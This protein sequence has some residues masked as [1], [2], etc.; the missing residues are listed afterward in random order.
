MNNKANKDQF[1]GYINTLWKQGQISESALIKIRNEYCKEKLKWQEVSMEKAQSDEQPA[2]V[3]KFQINDLEA[4]VLGKEA[5]SKVSDL[6]GRYQS[7]TIIEEKINS[8]EKTLGEINDTEIKTKLNESYIIRKNQKI[9]EQNKLTKERN[10][11]LILSLGIILILLAGIILATSTWRMMSNSTKT[12]TLLMVSILFFAMSSFT[13]KKLK[14]VKT[15]FAFWVLGNLFLPVILLSIGFFKL[16]GNYLSIGGQGRYIYGILSTFVCLIFFVYSIKKYKNMAFTWIS[17]ID[18]HLLYWFVLKQLH[19][20][21]NLRVIMTLIYIMILSCV[22]FKWKKIEGIYAFV[23]KT[24][25]YYAFINIIVG[26]FQVLGLSIYATVMMKIG[27]SY[28]MTQGLIISFGVIIL[29]IIIVLWT[30]DFKFQGGV[31]VSSLLILAIHMLCIT[32]EI[33]M[34]VFTYYILMSLGMTVVYGTMYYFNDFKYLKKGTDILII[35]SMALLDLFSIIPLKALF[36][37]ILLYILAT[38]IITTSKKSQNQVYV[39]ILKS[40]IPINIFIANLFALS[41]LKLIDNIFSNNKFHIGFIYIILNIGIIYCI[42]FIYGLKNNSSYKIYL[43]EGYAF[44]G[45]IYLL[46]LFFQIDRI[47]AGIAVVIVTAFCFIFS[48]NELKIK[49]YLYIF[50][51]MIILVLFDLELFFKFNKFT[52][53]ILKPQNIFLCISLV[54]TIIWW[55]AKEVWKKRLNSYIIGIYVFGFLNSLFLND[56]QNLNFMFLCFLIAALGL[57]GW[58]LYKQRKIKLMFIPIGC[59]WIMS[60]RIIYYFD[61]V[62]QIVAN[63]FIAC[64]IVAIGYVLYNIDEISG[65]REL[66]YCSIFSGISLICSI[67]VSSEE[68]VPYIFNV[69]SFIVFG[70]SLYYLSQIVKGY[71]FKRSL[72]IGAI[73]INYIAYG[74]FISE[75]DFLENFQ[76]DFLL[77]PSIIVLHLTINFYFPK[78]N[79]LRNIILRSWYVI[80]GIILLVFHKSNSSFEAIVY[81]ILCIISIIVGFVIQRRL[82]LIGGAV[83]LLIGVFLNTLNFWLNIPWWI[84]LLTGGALLI[85]FASKNEFNKRTNKESFLGK[86]INKIK[87]W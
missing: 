9:E 59:F 46:T 10:I 68:I 13:E 33:K 3:E 52:I 72:S 41:G 61:L 16:L 43:Y 64:V 60:L 24:L 86:L 15:S 7:E 37:A 22:Y 87:M 28:G 30:Y 5:F 66:L 36:V 49:I 8:V 44:L 6:E 57:M 75:L 71:K 47:I 58:F 83:F 69:F 4:E 17:L 67:V 81:C 70:G 12:I 40:I 26:I 2:S 14:I 1:L 32:F 11:S 56:F 79:I 63:W 23:F 21:Y 42:G 84:Y 51:T 35:I 55:R 25:K 62:N 80:I 39:F 53:F 82:Y 78:K 54:L 38:L 77:I 65:Y 48:K 74:R 29:T 19:L 34:D 73:F 50:L 45:L 18:L 20:D 31:F 27:K 85:L 76:I